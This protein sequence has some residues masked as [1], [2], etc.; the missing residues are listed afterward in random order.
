MMSSLRLYI[1]EN[2]QDYSKFYSEWVLL[3]FFLTQS[4]RGTILERS[5]VSFSNI[6]DLIRGLARYTRSWHYTQDFTV[7]NIVITTT[8]K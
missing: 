1:Y 4:R 7:S 8:L 2:I 3:S 6:F 5:G